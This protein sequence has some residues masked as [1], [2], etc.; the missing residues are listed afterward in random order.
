MLGILPLWGPV[1]L[2]LLGSLRSL[3]FESGLKVVGI[4]LSFPAVCY[5]IYLELGHPSLLNLELPEKLLRGW[6]AHTKYCQ[7]PTTKY[8]NMV[9]FIF[10]FISGSKMCLP[11]E[12]HPDALLG[13]QLVPYHLA[14]TCLGNLTFH[15]PFPALSKQHYYHCLNSLPA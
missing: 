3:W 5:C 6:M 7:V 9:L 1:T 2:C 11:K 13:I 12:E 8:F 4:S 14:S 15:N 10:Y